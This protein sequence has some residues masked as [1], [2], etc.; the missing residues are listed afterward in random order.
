[1]RLDPTTTST[2]FQA[3]SLSLRREWWSRM[4]GWGATVDLGH[5]PPAFPARRRRPRRALAGAA[6][7]STQ[8]MGLLPGSLKPFPSSW[9][10]RYV[11]PLSAGFLRFPGLSLAASWWWCGMLPAATRCRPSVL[12]PQGIP[13]GPLPREFPPIFPRYAAGLWLAADRLR[14]LPCGSRHGQSV[15]LRESL[16]LRVHATPCPAP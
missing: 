2:Q 14:A 6:P 3:V 12:G 4:L 15:G 5:W 8:R 11:G 9:I 7:C 1:M 16:Q 10:L 13:W